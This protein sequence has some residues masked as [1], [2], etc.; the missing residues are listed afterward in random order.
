MEEL[1]RKKDLLRHVA[2]WQF[3][4]SCV[5]TRVEYNVIDSCYRMVKN[6]PSVTEELI[7]EL[8][9]RSDR[10]A[11]SARNSY[12]TERLENDSIALGIDIAIAIIKGGEQG[13]V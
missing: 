4:N 12:G 7:S 11:R 13:G 1:I 3:A 2:E 6:F 8:E 5:E 9:R 10:Y